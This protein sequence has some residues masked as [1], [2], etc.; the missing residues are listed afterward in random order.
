[1]TLL[2]LSLLAATSLIFNIR[3]IILFLIKENSF[4][5]KKDKKEKVKENE[6]MR[7]DKIK[8]NF[9]NDTFIIENC[10]QN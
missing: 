6:R 8:T 3:Y 10:S 1:M 7:D 4:P 9:K 5:L 2:M